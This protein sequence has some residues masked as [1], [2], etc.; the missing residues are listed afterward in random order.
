M[1]VAACNPPAQAQVAAEY[2]VKA[3]IL[4]NVTRFVTWP[5]EAFLNAEAPLAVCVV[6]RDPFGMVLDQIMEGETANGRPIVVER[7]QRGS[8]RLTDCH[9]AFVS[10]SERLVVDEIVREVADSA[11]LTMAD[12]EGFAA[13]GGVIELRI[14]NSQIRFYISRAAAR[15]AQLELSSN[16]LNLA[17]LVGE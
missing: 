10:A 16:L 14:E 7:L 1:L 2:D 11:V 5:T 13:S 4:L 17:R 9:L 3:A 12:F 15:R 6:G 8:P